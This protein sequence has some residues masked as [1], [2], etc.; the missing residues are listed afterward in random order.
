MTSYYKNVECTLLVIHSYLHSEYLVV[1]FTIDI[2]VSGKFKNLVK[3]C[4]VEVILIKMN[5]KETFLSTCEKNFIN[6]AV[7]GGI[8]SMPVLTI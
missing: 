4:V 8:V 7:S 5:V 3:A 6:K 1:F 2:S